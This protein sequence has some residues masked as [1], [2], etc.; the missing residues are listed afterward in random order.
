MLENL[1][2]MPFAEFEERYFLKQPYVSRRPASEQLF[3]GHPSR[4]LTLME[5]KALLRRCRPQRAR[6]LHDVD[7]TRYVDGR[8]VA[9]S[10]GTDPVDANA[11]WRAFE[12]E[13]YSIRLVHP[14]Q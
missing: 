6:F 7:V 9:L 8:R 5:V 10:G 1:L 14:Q 13:G 4:M 3:E 12:R 11:V 2:R